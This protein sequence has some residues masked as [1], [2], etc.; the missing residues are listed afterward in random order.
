MAPG[1]FVYEQ[2][3]LALAVSE[4]V[5]E[6]IK[7]NGGTKAQIAVNAGVSHSS[8]VHSALQAENMTTHRIARILWACGYRAR[9]TL[10]RIW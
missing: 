10:E 3:K 1:T 9:I 2:E 8:Y 4:A 7:A 6:A 5:A